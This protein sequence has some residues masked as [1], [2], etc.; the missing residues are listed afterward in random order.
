MNSNLTQPYF[1]G[2]TA[3]HH[4]GDKSFLVQLINEIKEL[5]FDA[6]KFHLLLDCKSYMVKSHSAISSL[7]QWVFSKV[8]WKE[9]IEYSHGIGLDVIALCND[10]E[11]IDFILEENLPVSSIELH[12]T[13]LNDYFLMEKSSKFKGRIILGIGGSTI[14]EIDFAVTFLRNNGITNILLMHGF[15]NYPTNYKEVNL[16]R[17]LKIG[18]LFDLPIG[19]ADHTAP[20]DPNN[21][22]ISALAFAL[23]INVLE[24][25]IT[26]TDEKRIDYQ[27]AINR[28][29]FLKIKSITNILIDVVG[30]GSL[31][32]SDAEK[33]YG[34]TGT[35]KK[36]IVARILIPKDKEVTLDDVWFKR[37]KQSVY[38]K[39]NMLPQ[40][41]G[42]KTQ[43]DIQPD[44]IIDF[45]KL[46]Y[47]FRVGDFSQFQVNND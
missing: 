6:V 4:Q 3:F 25:H 24:K 42:L 46:N 44:E 28:D 17:G 10:P 36:A 47:E 20:K 16:K 7:E 23:G 33:K 15:Q 34:D 12:A 2:E 41:L 43:T 45:S 18:K 5:K 13:G 26:I 11:S 37:T 35:L 38:L 39:Q 1:I 31:E 22:L 30:T 14:D 21:E 40:I 27:A 29:Q 8:D 32:L 19:Y 9:I